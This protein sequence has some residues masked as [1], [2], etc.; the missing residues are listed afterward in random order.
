MK[1]LSPRGHDPFDERG[2][3]AC[4][5]EAAQV[6]FDHEREN[7]EGEEQVAAEVDVENQVVVHSVDPHLRGADG[8]DN[9]A[10]KGFFIRRKGDSAEGGQ[11]GG[12]SLILVRKEHSVEVR[13]T[14]ANDARQPQQQLQSASCFEGLGTEEIR[15][16]LSLGGHADEDP[17]LRILLATAALILSGTPSLADCGPIEVVRVD[18][19]DALQNVR[20]L[21][22]VC[23]VSAKPQDVFFSCVGFGG[24][25]PV[26]EM[27]RYAPN[28]P[29][30]ETVT[31]EVTFRA[32]PAVRRAEC[33]LTR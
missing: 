18:R 1:R 9:E 17:T 15:A 24:G 33:R 20:V 21:L 27:E 23:N 6:H 31:H 14:R 26:A 25:G 22:K 11:G 7:L 3:P 32:Q 29:A 12:I 30:G 19:P 13:Q 8:L 5:E 4:L 28:V 10:G 16:Y 2:A